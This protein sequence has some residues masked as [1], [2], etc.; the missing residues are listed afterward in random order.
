MTRLSGM[1]IVINEESAMTFYQ[2]YMRKINK[3][4]PSAIIM[5]HCWAIGWF[6]GTI[7]ETRA[8]PRLPVDLC[9]Q[10]IGIAIGIIIMTAVQVHVDRKHDNHDN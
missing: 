9:A 8:L 2:D 7:Y 4:I 1:T 10:L 3:N 6:M 5:V